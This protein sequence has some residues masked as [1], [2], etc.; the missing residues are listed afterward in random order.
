MIK[1][2]AEQSKKSNSFLPV[3][4]AA[5]AL[6]CVCLAGCSNKKVTV[7]LPDGAKIKA[8]LA[9]TSEETE[10]GMMFRKE[11]APSKG[12]LFVFEQDEPRMFWM[13]NTLIDLDMIFINS[14]GTVNNV[15][16]NVPRSYVYT[17]DSQVAYRGGF[18]KYV[19]ELA[20]GSAKKHNIEQ[21]SQ[22]KFKLPK[23][24]WVEEE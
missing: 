14:D 1:S 3:F 4:L 7:T 10:R 12:M 9:L 17:P 16:A 11:L 24:K 20:A 18:G 23:I 13:K 19:L 15:A 22:I 21:G 5:A 8:E 2:K 6:C